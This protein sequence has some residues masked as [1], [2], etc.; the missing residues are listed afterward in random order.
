MLANPLFS[1]AALRAAFGLGSEEAV[2][3][4]R[5]NRR[6]SMTRTKAGPGRRA[7]HKPQRKST[8]VKRWLK[9]GGLGGLR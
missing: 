5:G 4:Y 8:K 7:S 6:Y 3:D 2:D 9:R 1:L